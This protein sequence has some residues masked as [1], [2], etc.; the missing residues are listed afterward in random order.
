[1]ASRIKRLCASAALIAVMAFVAASALVLF[2]PGSGGE[3]AEWEAG[4]RRG[5]AVFDASPLKMRIPDASMDEFVS[6]DKK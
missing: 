2:T 5:G 6:G 3:A 4:G 1:M